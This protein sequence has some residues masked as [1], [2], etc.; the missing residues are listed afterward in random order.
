MSRFP[1]APTR[2]REKEREKEHALEKVKPS[3]P[4][5]SVKRGRQKGNCEGEGWGAR[6]GDGAAILSRGA[7]VT[8]RVGTLLL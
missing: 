8:P 3:D 1:N 5:K 2:G 6:L 4:G 7:A